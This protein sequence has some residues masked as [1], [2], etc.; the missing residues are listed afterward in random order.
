MINH[1]VTLYSILVS[2]DYSVKEMRELVAAVITSQPEKYTA[3]ILGRSCHDYVQWILKDDSWGG[4]IIIL[5][6]YSYYFHI[7]QVL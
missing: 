3:A 1:C 5:S 7:I 4:R 2:T 6:G